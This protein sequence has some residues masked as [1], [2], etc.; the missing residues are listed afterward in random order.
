MS[1]SKTIALVRVALPCNVPRA[2][3]ARECNFGVVFQW[4]VQISGVD[5]VDD[6]ACKS[7]H[8]EVEAENVGGGKMHVDSNEGREIKP[9]K[10]CSGVQN[11]PLHVGYM[12]RRAHSKAV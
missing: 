1:I 8:R 11:R 6:M 5:V 3:R 9:H 12:A 10:C 7:K 2:V 4:R